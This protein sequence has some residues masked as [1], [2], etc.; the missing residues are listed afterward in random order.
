MTLTFKGEPIELEGTLPEIG[1]AAPAFTVKDSEGNIF[2]KEDLF[3]KVTIISVVPDIDTSVCSIQSNKFNDFAKKAEGIN[4]ISISNNTQE[5]L[6]AWKDAQEATIPMYNDA[7]QFAKDYGIYL[8]S[9]D[10]TA[11]SV[12]VLNPNNE[13]AYVELVD[14]VSSEPDYDKAITAAEAAK[15]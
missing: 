15:K 9:L 4:V 3:G 10:K 5:A 11:R 13:V 8:P 6:G 7:T 1:L 12:F 2:T 14:E